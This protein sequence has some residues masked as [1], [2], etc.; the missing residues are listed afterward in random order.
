MILIAIG[1]ISY[2]YYVRKE[3]KMAINMIG[4]SAEALQVC[5]SLNFI[6]ILQ[7]IFLLIMTFVM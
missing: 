6:P 5:K 4:S 2:T 3:I 1:F 7:M